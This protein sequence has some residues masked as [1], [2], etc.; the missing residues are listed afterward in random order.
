MVVGIIML[1]VIAI[2]IQVI[3]KVVDYKE[4]VSRNKE[5]VDLK[6]KLA[7]AGITQSSELGE[8][9]VEVCGKTAQLA[10]LK[11][12][13]QTLSQKI[14][15]LEVEYEIEQIVSEESNLLIKSS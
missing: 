14:V 12:E 4:E 8:S 1:T 10:S 9:K 3:V 15:Q 6:S 2:T 11:K 5:I 13:Q 7:L